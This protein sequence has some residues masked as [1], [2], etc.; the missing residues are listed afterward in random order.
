M[1]DSAFMWGQNL[2]VT[3]AGTIKQWNKIHLGKYLFRSNQDINCLDG[4]TTWIWEK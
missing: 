1:N 2:T 4:I 3:Y